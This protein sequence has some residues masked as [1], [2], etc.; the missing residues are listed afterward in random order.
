LLKSPHAQNRVALLSSLSLIALS[1]AEPAPAQTALPDINVNETRAAPTAAATNAAPTPIGERQDGGASVFTVDEG[2]IDLATGGGG[3]N[4]LRSVSNLPGV[5]APAIDPYGLAN[6]PGGNKGIRI[7]GALSQHGDSLSTVDGIPLSGIDPGVGNTWLINNEN[8]SGVTLYQG[9]VP[10][11]VNSYFT[12]V[13][14][15]DSNILWPKDKMGGEI[16]QSYGSFA[17]LRTFARLDSGYFLNN[18]TKFFISGSFT[19]A[20]KWRGY[21]Q[22]P[23]D[24]GNFSAGIESHLSDSLDVKAFVGH[25]NYQ[26]NTYAGLTYAQATNLSKYRTYDFTANPTNPASNLVNWYG[27]NKQSFSVWTAFA[28]INYHFNNDTVLTLKPY[29]LNENGYYLDGMSNGMVRKW[30]IN[31]DYYGGIAEIK[32]RYA[33]T[34]LL[35]GYWGGVGNLPGPPTAWKMYAPNQNGGL[36]FKSWG[37]LSD[38]TDPNVYQA[39]YGMAGRQFGDLHTQLGLRYQ[40]TTLPGINAM[41]TSG[42]GDVSYDSALALSSGVIANRSVQSR[43]IGNT[44]PFLSLAY[45]V[46]PD[47]Q[48]RASLGRNSDAPAL[49]AW[50]TYQQNAAAFLAKGVTAQQMWNDL[51]PATSNALDLGFGYKFATPFGAG[52]FE[53]TFFYARNFN[54]TVSYDPGIGVAY[55]QNVGSSRTLGAQGLVRLDTTHDLSFFTAWSYQSMVFVD[56]LPVLSGASAATVAATKVKGNQ[57]PDVPLWVATLGAEW[58]ISRLTVTP[59]LHLF[60]QVYGDAAHLQ[61]IAGYGTFD[62]QFAWRQPLPVGEA[63]ASLSVTNLFNQAYIGQI[64][65]GYYQSTSSSGIYYPGAPRAVVAKLDWKW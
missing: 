36:T 47:L 22:S 61:P 44:L 40:W 29:Y 27:Y 54:Q 4:T 19:D 12:S 13:G 25:T 45:D 7:R 37:I 16:S 8:L 10:S 38:Q 17:F 58:R 60:S 57:M 51:K 43:T 28:E 56:N 59:I 11:N 6:L 65:S 63:T 14:V 48:L 15:I 26:A 52:S 30:L 53:P 49:D 34:N 62:L 41:N 24:M 23:N 33:D 20:N 35:A 31:H 50:P 39:L 46:T 42:V 55:G 1:L 5:M 2:G 64:S 21:G 9:P 18:T 3:T 32:T